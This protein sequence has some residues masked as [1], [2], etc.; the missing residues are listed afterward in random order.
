M[1]DFCSKVTQVCK[2]GTLDENKLVSINLRHQDLVI[3]G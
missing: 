3:I 1:D 2:N